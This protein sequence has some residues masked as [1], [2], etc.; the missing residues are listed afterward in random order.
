MALRIVRQLFRLWLVLSLL[1]V[2]AI[3]TVTW[4]SQPVEWPGTEVVPHRAKIEP[5]RETEVIPDWSNVVPLPKLGELS[6][7]EVGF[8]PPDKDTKKWEAT[9]PIDEQQR[10][11]LKFGVELA[12]IS[13]VLVLV[14]GSALGRILRGFKNWFSET[15]AISPN[16]RRE[17]HFYAEATKRVLAT[18]KARNISFFA[19]FLADANSMFGNRADHDKHAIFVRL[20]KVPLL[21][22][23]LAD[24]VL[25]S[26]STYLPNRIVPLRVRFPIVVKP[27]WG[28]QSIGIVGIHDENALWRF[29]RKRRSPHIAQHFI[30]DGLEIGVSFTR[31]PAGPP[32]FLGVTHKEPV[33]SIKEWKNGI[34]KVPRCFYHHDV[35]PNVD[36]ERLIELCI[37]IAEALGTKSFRFDAFVSR[38]GANLRFDTLQIF[39]VNTGAFAMD[40]FL[41]DTRHSPQFVIEELTRKYTY[42]LLWGARLTPHPE[43]SVMRELVLHYIYCYIVTVL[44][45]VSETPLMCKLRDAIA[46]LLELMANKKTPSR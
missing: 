9:P 21:A 27:I 33:S 8:K 30:L 29:L 18:A 41:F 7:P 26:S 10:A 28:W 46:I 4:Q 5:K 16:L 32:D 15:L 37:A 13:P 11:A 2:G 38:E 45:H 31:N 20:S 22:P 42:L 36:C 39:E 3:G 6:D 25:I 34:C 44:G 24:T 19:L 14:F 17:L 12:I 43:L 40:E 35:T 23:Y 1:W